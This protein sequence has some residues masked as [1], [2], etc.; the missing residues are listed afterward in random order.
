MKMILDKQLTFQMVNTWREL[1]RF[2]LLLDYDNSTATKFC[3]YD[4]MFM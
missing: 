1:Q 2:I 4:A 3:A